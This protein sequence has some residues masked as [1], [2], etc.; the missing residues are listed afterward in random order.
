MAV[1]NL[2][3]GTTQQ[4]PFT[5]SDL[6][7]T[8]GIAV[9]DWG[10]TAARLTLVVEIS[11]DAAATWLTVAT[12]T[13][14]Q[15][16]GGRPVGMTLSPLAAVCSVCGNLYLPG[17]GRY[18]RALSHSTVALKPG[19]TLAQL[20]QLC[21]FPIVSTASFLTRILVDKQGFD[22]DPIYVTRT[23]HTPVQNV[24]VP[25][26]VRLRFVVTGAAISSTLTTTTSA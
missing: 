7:H 15:G 2:P 5:I 18:D 6:E 4:A 24:T 11:V 3:I 20:G 25:R 21:P 1:L 10:A 17:D 12:M 13:S 23:F 26:Q 8:L 9:A 16:G 14:A 19:V 22:I